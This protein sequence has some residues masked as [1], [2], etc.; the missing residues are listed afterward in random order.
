MKQTLQMTANTIG[1]DL[2]ER[3]V[4]E[5][6]MLPDVWPKL[7]KNKQDDVIGRLRTAVEAAVTMAVHLIASNNRTAVPAV[8]ENFANTKSGIKGSLVFSKTC[9]AR[10][11]LFDSQGQEVLVIVASATD[12]MG[13]TEGVKGEPDQRAMD[14]G[15]EYDPN[16]DGKGME[17]AYQPGDVID[18]EFKEVPALPHMPL[19]TELDQAYR[20]GWVAAERELPKEACPSVRHELVFQWTQGWT[21][22]HAGAQPRVQIDAVP[23]A[24]TPPANAPQTPIEALQAAVDAENAQHDAE[25]Q[26]SDAAPG[27]SD[28]ASE[29]VQDKA[30]PALKPSAKAKPVATKPATK[31]GGRK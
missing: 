11:E 3:L 19:Q 28:A 31:K 22:W 25:N 18:A 20:D 29:A 7:T 5:C 6:R 9:P 15:H 23:E 30:K 16:G 26:N 1:R 4:M 24:A 21:D 10:H 12:H 17:G 27:E 13:D 8:L 14:L 2:L